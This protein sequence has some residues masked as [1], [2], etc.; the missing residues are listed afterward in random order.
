MKTKFT[1]QQLEDWKAYEKVRA[2]GRFNMLFP[3]A[4]QA[5][6]LSQDRYNFVMDN[7]AALQAEYLIRGLRRI[8]REERK[9]GWK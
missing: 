4:Q 1:K 6:G 7:Y 8:K 3:Q 5:A 9:L 2:G